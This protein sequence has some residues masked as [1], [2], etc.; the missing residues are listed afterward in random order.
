M[1]CIMLNSILKKYPKLFLA[2]FSYMLL[3]FV[4]FSTFT[5]YTIRFSDLRF[6][7]KDFEVIDSVSLSINDINNNI[8]TDKSMGKYK[9]LSYYLDNNYRI[10]INDSKTLFELINEN[11][12]R[13]CLTL[14]TDYNFRK[15]YRLT[16]DNNYYRFNSKI[17]I[18]L[19][20]T[21]GE[22]GKYYEC[23]IVE[24]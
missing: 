9:D 12:Y 3:L 23:Y 20:K 22:P 5:L 1:K 19:E 6:L 10:N 2:Y 7:I 18:Y 16:L 11:K 24:I 15:N 14:N 8:N 13:V 4:F 21:T 17:K